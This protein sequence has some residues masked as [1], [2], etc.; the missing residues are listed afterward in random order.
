MKKLLIT[1]VLFIGS[2]CSVAKPQAQAETKPVEANKVALKP[3]VRY[4]MT[5]L[6]DTKLTSHGSNR[7][8][9]RK[10]VT[11]TFSENLFG[12]PDVERELI[13]GL[14]YDDLSTRL[15]I[16]AEPVLDEGSILNILNKRM[17]YIPGNP[18]EPVEK[19]TDWIIKKV[20]ELFQI[21]LV[22]KTTKK[23]T[24]PAVPQ[25]AAFF[26]SMTVCDF[27]KQAC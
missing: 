17:I 5:G 3:E 12:D 20:E 4:A 23:T 22:R 18:N 21:K 15:I 19:H 25:M 8:I 26:Y 7:T 6:V 16:A 11:I 10:A 2:A 24:S 27:T 13:R 9:I 14:D 1:V